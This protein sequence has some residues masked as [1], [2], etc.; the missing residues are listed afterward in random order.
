VFAPKT[1]LIA[2]AAAGTIAVAAASQA[3]ADAPARGANHSA[4]RPAKAEARAARPSADGPAKAGAL[5]PDDRFARAPVVANYR[6]AYAKA[7]D[8]GVAPNDNL[9]EGRQV[10][11]DRLL[12]ATPGLRSAVRDE[13]ARSAPTATSSTVTTTT[14]SA[15]SYGV[16]QATLDAIASCE[17]GGDPS[18]VSADGTYRGLYQFDESTWASVGGSGDPAAASVGEQNMRA[19]MLYSEVGASAW[20]VCGQ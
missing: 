18:A 3:G 17:S 14:S 6:A 9:A 20:P 1:K 8:V 15:S 13:A 4:D 10:S 11:G 2:L 5:G 12:R 7:R 19:A 16:S